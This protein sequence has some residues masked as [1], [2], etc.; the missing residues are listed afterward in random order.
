VYAL[1]IYFGTQLLS[2]FLLLKAQSVFFRNKVRK[3]LFVFSLAISLSGIII[4][5]AFT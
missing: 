1:S 2:G 5:E 3:V 4:S